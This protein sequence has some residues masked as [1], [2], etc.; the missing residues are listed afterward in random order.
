ML[1]FAISTLIFGSCVTGGQYMG[2]GYL[3]L[4]MLEK[5]GSHYL[6]STLSINWLVTTFLNECPSTIF[7]WSGTGYW[8]LF[9]QY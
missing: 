5:T 7:F 9:F 3:F 1:L 6:G 2:T 8:L 4:S